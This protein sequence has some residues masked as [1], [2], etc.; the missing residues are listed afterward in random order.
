MVLA[1]AFVPIFRAPVPQSRTKL[2]AP[3]P[4]PIVIVLSIAFFPIFR[5][6]V[7]Q[8]RIKLVAPVPLPIVMVPIVSRPKSLL[9]P[10]A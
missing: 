4:L 7:P 10:S 9:F 1:I 3:V 8:S 5:A 2:V 6:P